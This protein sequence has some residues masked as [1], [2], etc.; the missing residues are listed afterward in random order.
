MSKDMKILV[1]GVKGQ[2]GYDC[3]KE[4]EKRGYTN[5]VGIDKEELDITNE[6][7]VIEYITN[8]KPDVV[9][10]NAAW[11]AVDK[12]EEMPDKVYEVNALGTKYIA[13]ACNMVNAKMVYI[14]TDYVFDGL[15][16]KAF[17][18][19]DPKKGL[20]IYGSTK[21]QGEDFVKEMIDNYFIVRISWVF[22]K[23]GNNFVN[24][25]LKL[26]DMGKTELNVVCDQIGSVTYTADLAVLLCDMIETEKYGIYHATNEG[27]ISWADFAEE[28]FR[29]AK[30]DVKVN[31]VTTEEYRAL[32]PNQ[33]QRP[34]NSRMS[35]KS[36]ENAGFSLLPDWKDALK[37]Y[38][39][40]LGE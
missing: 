34:L 3:V 33:A 11:T 23:N 25:M 18:I 35:K 19:D 21:S 40:E 20:S 7:A 30:R 16:E 36:L 37:R 5:V 22:G 26:A 4:L 8:Y 10:H 24:T 32:V 9:M 29:Q 31:Y 12:A 15:G 27:F 14:S 2:L 28:I 39:K 17:E 6:D 13:K 38:L 1:T